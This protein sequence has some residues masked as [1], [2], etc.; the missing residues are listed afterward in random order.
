[1]PT[2]SKIILTN[3]DVQ[4]AEPF[5]NNLDYGELAINY[6][7]GK[8]F[9]KNAGD[10]IEVIASTDY[11]KEL[12]DHISDNNPHNITPEEIGLSNVDNTADKDK[13]ISDQ[14]Q[15]QLDLKASLLSVS[16]LQKDINELKEFDNTKVITLDAL[17][18][19]STPGGAANLGGIT[20]NDITGEFNYFP[21]D[22][23]ALGGVK[24]TALE[25]ISPDTL[26]GDGSLTYNSSNGEFTYDKPTLEGLDGLAPSKL[27]VKYGTAS[28]QLSNLAAPEFDETTRTL[29]LKYTQLDVTGINKNVSSLV[30]LSGVDADETNLGKIFDT[31]IDANDKNIVGALQAIDDYVGNL[32]STGDVGDA[33]G[34]ATSDIG[35]LTNLNTEI[36]SPNP[37]NLVNAINSVYDDVSTNTT[38]IGNLTG[39]IG[40]LTSL[41]TEISSPN[42]TN[43]VD[44][45]NEVYGDIPTGS[46]ASQDSDEIVITG[47]TITGVSIEAST[48]VS[49]QQLGFKNTGS[50][51]PVNQA[52]GSPDSIN[53]SVT[54][55]SPAGTIICAGHVFSSDTPETFTVNN[56]FVDETDVIILSFKKGNPRIDH[57]VTSIA[58]GQFEISLYDYHNQTV[59]TTGNPLEINFAVIKHDT[60]S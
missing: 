49:A 40:V 28:T 57:K 45:I 43:L 52:D 53:D 27:E 12:Q 29:T 2:Y 41:N 16:E 6:A 42:P 59:N 3:S 39:D 8:L 34:D 32:A 23:E 18:V 22:L 30:S 36:S 38:S 55:N 47:G 13:P 56:S 5:S 1:M 14:T 58:D 7:D 24:L 10:E 44:A 50:T 46:M 60:S 17:K 4:N 9:F 37:T 48:V 20:Y 31:I 35:V 51:A 25:I 21:P 54:I 26:T 15:A 33:V 19:S 11:L